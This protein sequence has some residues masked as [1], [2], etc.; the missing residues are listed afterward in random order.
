VEAD[1]DYFSFGNYCLT[2]KPSHIWLNNT[3]T[4]YTGLCVC[5][6]DS[7]LLA[8]LPSLPVP[9]TFLFYYPYYPMVLDTF[10]HAEQE[11]EQCERTI[12]SIT[13]RRNELT[14][15]FFVEHASASA[16]ASAKVD[17]L[18]LL[19]KLRTVK[20][21]L[22]EKFD[23]QLLATYMA[24]GVVPILYDFVPYDFVPYDLIENVQYVK[25]Y[26]VDCDY[27]NIKQNCLTYYN[28]H[29]KPA[30]CMRKLLDFIFI[31]NI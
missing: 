29:I 11:Q 4:K 3:I 30:A 25:E 16:S 22:M 28:D 31:R 5:N 21:G 24:L 23:M 8:A 1:I 9:S 7:S 15:D 2:D 14:D 17:Y 10:L 18:A 19:G 20:Y 26:N 6:Y 27:E 12:E 13:V